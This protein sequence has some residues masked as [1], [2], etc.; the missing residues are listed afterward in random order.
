MKPM[1]VFKQHDFVR[2]LKMF[3]DRWSFREVSKMTYNDVTHSKLWRIVN[4]NPDISIHD[5]M[6]LCS[7]MEKSP[8]VYY[9]IFE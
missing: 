7:V 4:V 5:F 9:A 6:T 1:Y 8:E 2:D 3:C